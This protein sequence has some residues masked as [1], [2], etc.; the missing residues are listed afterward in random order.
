MIFRVCMTPTFMVGHG[1]YTLSYQN[2]AVEAGPR[3]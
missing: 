3:T 2:D 1:T